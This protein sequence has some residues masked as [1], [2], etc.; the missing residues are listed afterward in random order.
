[1]PERID[2]T[3]ADGIATL[4]FNR[5]KQLNAMNRRMM[6]EIISALETIHADPKIRVAILTGNGKAFM[7]GADIKEYAAQ[8]VAEF[9]SFQSRG[10][11]LYSL[12]EG[13]AKPVI[14]AV[15]GY[16]FGGGMEIALACDLVFASAE[17]QFGLPEI[18][19]ALIPGGGGTQRLVKKT[20][21]NFA[22]EMLLSGR[23]AMP[24]ELL[25]QGFVNRICPPN[26]L[27]AQARAFAADLCKRP[28]DVLRALKQ[29][30]ELAAGPVG[31]SAYRIEMQWLGQFY[32]SEI[33]QERIQDFLKRSQARSQ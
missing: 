4:A 11:T 16:A 24:E 27:L 13:S 9:E 18:K 14:A 32:R 1:M 29:L 10:R 19:L 15:N 12:I 8:T 31:E 2:L 28:P 20:S 17:A 22:K 21:L 7:A 25:Q 26:E 3:V 5:P 23:S 6:D 33:G 30:A